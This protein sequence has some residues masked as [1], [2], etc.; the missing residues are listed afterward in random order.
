[1][2]DGVVCI[3]IR[4]CKTDSGNE[5]RTKDL[6]RKFQRNGLCDNKIKRS[7]ICL[8]MC[9]AKKLCNSK[10]CFLASMRTPC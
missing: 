2:L 3:H 10:A 7:Q 4:V 5:K 1:M 9:K 6:V 8:E